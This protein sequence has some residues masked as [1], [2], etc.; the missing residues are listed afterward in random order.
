MKLI[1]APPNN[2]HHY[3]NAPKE[4]RQFDALKA[5]ALDAERYPILA[6][7]WESILIVG[8][9]LAI[10]DNCSVPLPKGIRYEQ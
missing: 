5:T 9:K 1:S 3:E 6:K 7:H 10:N 8:D 4:N 2:K